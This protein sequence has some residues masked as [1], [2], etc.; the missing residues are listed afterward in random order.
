MTC[1]DDNR[2]ATFNGQS[3]GPR[4][5]REHDQRPGDERYLGDV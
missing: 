4:F 1:D 5:G 3:V 2:L